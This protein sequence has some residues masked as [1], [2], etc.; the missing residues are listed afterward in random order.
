VQAL[1]I[2]VRWRDQMLDKITRDNEKMFDNL[3]GQARYI[4]HLETDLMRS[5]G[6]P[7]AQFLAAP[8]TNKNDDAKPGEAVQP[9]SEERPHPDQRNLATG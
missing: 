8:S 2:D 9:S 5:G 3:Q 6:A 7:D 4:G 1:T